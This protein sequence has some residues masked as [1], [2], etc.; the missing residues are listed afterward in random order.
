E[1][2]EKYTKANKLWR[3]NTEAIEYSSVVELDVSKIEPSVAGPKRPQDKILVKN[4]KN[5][6]K[7]LLKDEFKRDYVEQ[8][9]R[10]YLD[11]ISRWGYEGGTKAQPAKYQ[12][13]TAT[14]EED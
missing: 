8:G 5:K 11:A 13:A 6:F 4:L 12:N 9:D 7:D 2:V 3:E 10:T 1:R 14:I